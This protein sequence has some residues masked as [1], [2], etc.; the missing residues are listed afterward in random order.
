MTLMT[1]PTRAEVNLDALEHNFTRIKKRAGKEAK[2]LAI[3]KAN[4]YGHGAVEI[5]RSLQELGVDFL[6]VATCEE[7]IELRKASITTPIILLG[8]SFT[9]QATAVL[10]H[11]LIPVVYNLESARELS[12]HAHRSNR[13]V[14]I[15]VKI[16][17]GMGRLGVLPP[18]TSH[19]FQTL[20]KLD[21]LEVEGILT[22][23]NRSMNS[24]TWVFIHTINTS[25]IALPL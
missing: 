18:A 15:H 25:P 19:F 3:V 1:R 17:T 22:H 10:H 6:G 13:H 5:S 4:A 7:G 2:I 12:Q 24:T 8:G 21:G 14:K 11:D 9:G 20:T 16:D 23:L